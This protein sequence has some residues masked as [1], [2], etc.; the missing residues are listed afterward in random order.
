[1]TEQEVASATLSWWQYVL[2]LA[3]HIVP[4]SLYFLSRQSQKRDRRNNAK[5]HQFQSGV[6][7]EIDHSLASLKAAASKLKDV[8]FASRTGASLTR[9]IESCNE[10]VVSA[11]DQ[12]MEALATADES[13]FADGND[14]V[15][16][17]TDTYDQ[18]LTSIQK[19]LSS[20]HDP[21]RREILQETAKMIETRIR[22]VRARVEN[23]I[24][25]CMK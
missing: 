13:A 11:G 24:M 9:D 1:M 2:F 23:Q 12:L 18:C 5:L 10:A 7:S 21:K 14:W 15:Q 3:P 20:P 19:A 4:I 8:A 6:Q 22:F 17:F 25:D 16:I